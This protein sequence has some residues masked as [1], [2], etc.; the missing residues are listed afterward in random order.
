[1]S[2]AVLA[3]GQALA[4]PAQQALRIT[5][6]SVHIPYGHDV[7]V[8]GAAPSE[9][10]HTVVL[11]FARHGDT[12]WQ[13]LSSSTIAGDGSFRLTG[14]L[15]QSG[16][17][18]A[19]DTSTG[20]QMPLLARASGGGSVAPTSAPVPVDVAAGVRVRP[21]PISVLGGQAILVRGRLLPGLS[22][23]KVSL[24]GRENGRWQTLSSTRTRS[25]GRFV[26]RYVADAARHESI[27]V[28][29]AGD[30]KN[31]RATASAGQMTV[32][33]EAGASWYEDGGHTACGFHAHYGV[34]N[35]TLPC[36]TKVALRYNGRS[37]TATVD[38]RGPYVGGRD[39]DLNQNTA[40]ALGFGGVGTVW[41]S[42]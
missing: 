4:A 3:A 18:R 25:A 16:V 12:A 30:Q 36:G 8:R 5:P 28:K 7:I 26:L 15:A 23:R 40:A 24:Q 19:L 33:R 1:M 6:R 14:T 13:R 32:Y 37:V 11:E 41:S 42:Q 29:F 22:G 2:A 17:L 31:G 27:R 9:A 34:A 39:W 35:R 21:R 38:D 10:G 20:S